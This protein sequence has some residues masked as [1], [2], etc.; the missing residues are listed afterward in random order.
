MN[1]IEGP[2][3][4][5][6][7]VLTNRTERARSAKGWSKQPKRAIHV[8]LGGA[9]WGPMFVTIEL[10]SSEPAMVEVGQAVAVSGFVLPR[11][12]EFAAWLRP[13]FWLGLGGLLTGLMM[14]SRRIVRRRRGASSARASR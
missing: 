6:V 1:W 3:D 10:E 4:A 14:A 11:G 2:D 9:R 12:A 8:P 13:L 7:R 5:L